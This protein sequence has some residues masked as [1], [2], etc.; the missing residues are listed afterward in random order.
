MNY[1]IYKIYSLLFLIILFGIGGGTLY[2][3]YYYKTNNIVIN[4]QT[5]ETLLPIENDYNASFIGKEKFVDLHGALNETIGVNSMNGVVKLPNGQLTLIKEEYSEEIEKEIRR[6]ADNIEELAKYCKEKKIPFL[7]VITPDKVSMYDEDI[8]KEIHDTSN[9]IIDTFVDE[10]NQIGLEYIDLR[11]EFHEINPDLYTYFYRTDHHWTTEAGFLCYQMISDWIQENT[12]ISIAK[13]YLNRNSYYTRWYPRSFY[14][15]WAQRTGSS[16]AGEPDD[17]SFLIPNF[18]TKIIR[19]YDWNEA[20]LEE[21]FY[22][23]EYIDSDHPSDFYDQVL[24]TQLATRNMGEHNGKKMML[25][26][27]SFSRTVNPFFMLSFEYFDFEDGY[28]SSEITKQK[29]EDYQ[30]DIIILIH[31]P[32]NNYG[33][34]ESFEYRVK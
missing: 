33:R 32:W 9:Q 6:E 34:K 10:A 2:N 15:S 29:I 25:I 28:S 26:G 22:F 16:F 8:P 17:F 3:F 30:P 31:S 4:E 11:K 13:K 18:E 23:P 27:D 5:D 1:R 21:N 14:G 19:A 20:R 24:G 7:Y 12:D